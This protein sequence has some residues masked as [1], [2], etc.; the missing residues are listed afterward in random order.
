MPFLKETNLFFKNYLIPQFTERLYH[1]LVEWFFKS[2]PEYL[3]KKIKIF[4]D[5]LLKPRESKTHIS[6]DDCQGVCSN[7]AIVTNLT[8]RFVINRG[9]FYLWRE[10]E[11]DSNEKF[12]HLFDY[13]MDEQQ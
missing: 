6:D 5:I 2:Q 10:R 4:G 3:L 1:N 9:C 11:K 8:E 12:L 13:K 7:A